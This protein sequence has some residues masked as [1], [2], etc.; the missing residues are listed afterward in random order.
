MLMNIFVHIIITTISGC[1]VSYFTHWVCN[2]NKKEKQ[3][4]LSVN[5]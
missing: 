3:A 5:T 2:H 4:A 1:I